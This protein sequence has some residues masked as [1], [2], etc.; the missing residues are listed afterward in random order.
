MSKF[1]V[2]L[3]NTLTPVTKEEWQ[4]LFKDSPNTFETISVLQASG[5]TDFQLSSILVRHDGKPSLLLPLFL[6]QHYLGAT[7]DGDLKAAADL[8]DRFLPR[9]LRMPLLRVGIVDQQWGEI[10]YDRDLPFEKLDAAWNFALQALEMFCSA[11]GVG[12]VAFTEFTPETGWM[13]PLAKLNDFVVA[14]GAPFIQIPLHYPTVEAYLM[15]LPKDMRHFLRRSV[16]KSHPVKLVRTREPEPWLDSI[17]ELYLKQVEKSDL[18]L[19]GTQCKAYFANA[20]KLD[21]T[22]EFFLYLL[23]EQLIGFEMV[24]HL[25]G[26][27][28]S[29]FVAIDDG[30]GRNH[31]L[32]FRSWMELV[33]CCIEEGLPLV[34]LGCTGEELKTKLGDAIIVPSGVMFKHMNPLVNKLFH[35]ARQELSY[36][37]KVSV[38]QANLGQGWILA[39]SVL[40]DQVASDSA[41]PADGAASQDR[42]SKFNQ[43][44]A[45]HKQPLEV[46]E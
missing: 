43:L 32:Y 11:H 8:A 35:H 41:Q 23:D 24:C 44:V 33:S 10:G 46:L 40:H 37:S 2:E 6:T 4:Q 30:P 18:N 5:L 25:P 12:I 13:L 27:L 28:L 31:N 42:P 22:A 45:H 19:N 9:L 36:T 29:K 7:L 3:K 21:P 16:R 34:D 17:Y 38:P 14:D 1:T 39:A 26:S 20:C 15:S